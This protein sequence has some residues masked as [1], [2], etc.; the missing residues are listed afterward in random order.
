MSDR[1]TGE[2]REAEDRRIEELR[3]AII[4]EAGRYVCFEPW[5]IQ[6]W[7]RRQHVRPMPKAILFALAVRANEFG[8]CFVKSTTL[9]EE[10]GIKRRNIW[11]QIKTLEAAGLLARVERKREDNATLANGYW[12]PFW[13]D[14]TGWLPSDGRW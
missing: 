11:R 6:N 1:T 4:A 8:Y 14:I 2:A 10:C 3:E 9:A 13:R 5:S 12:L 7:A